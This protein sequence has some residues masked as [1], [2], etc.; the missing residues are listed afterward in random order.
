MGVVNTIFESDIEEVILIL[1]SFWK[2]GGV[3]FRVFE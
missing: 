3:V 2:W 1:L